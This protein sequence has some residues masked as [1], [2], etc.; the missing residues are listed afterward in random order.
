VIAVKDNG[1]GIERIY[2]EKV[3]DL[4]QQLPDNASKSKGMGLSICKRIMLNHNSWIMIDPDH[5]E[6][7]RLLLF[8]PKVR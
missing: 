7:T 2:H 5:T 1:P 6:G 8:F 3:F 4:F